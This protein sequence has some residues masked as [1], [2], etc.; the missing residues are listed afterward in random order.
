M[1]TKE[2]NIA[3]NVTAAVEHAPLTPDR[4][5]EAKAKLDRLMK[6]ESKLVKGMFQFF[7]CPGMSAKITVKKYPGPEKGG[8][9]SFA[10]EMVDG[11]MYEVPLYVA[12][13]L[14]GIDVT[15]EAIGGK[16]GTCGYK[17]SSFLMD[18]NGV[19]VITHDKSKRRFGFQSMEFAG[20][21][22]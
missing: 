17:I 21:E 13:F 20:G 9:P 14:N 12:R 6:E 1:T 8:I 19:P 10:K 2:L 16:L 3:K 4:K 7:E 22:V 5:A 15:A 11:Q 18:A